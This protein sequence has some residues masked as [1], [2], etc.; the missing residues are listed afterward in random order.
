MTDEKTIKAG[1]E[2][3]SKK[4]SGTLKLANASFMNMSVGYGQ[5]NPWAYTQIDKL[6]DI[7]EKEF[8]KLVAACRFFYRHDPIVSTV[9]NKMIDIGI[10]DLRFKKTKLSANEIRIVES[11]I[12]DLELFAENMALE[13][14]ISGLVVP[15]VEYGVVSKD[16]MQPYGIKKYSRLILPQSLWLRD[17]TTIKINSALVDTPS[18]FVEIPENI[19][20]FIMNGGV[21]PDGTEDKE[22]YARLAEHYPEFVA[23]VKNG[24]KYVLL[25][26]D[27]IFRR[28]YTT[29]SPYPIPYLNSVIESLRH[30]RNIKRMDYA[31]AARVIGAIQ[32]FKLGSDD[33][34]VTQDQDEQFEA[35]KEQMTYRYS[36]GRD[37]E[38]IFQLFA[39]H[40]LSIEWI[41]PD[42]AALLDDTKYKDVNNSIVLGLGFPR[43]LMT[44]ETERTGTS[45]HEF[46]TMSPIK[47]MDRFRHRIETVLNKIITKVFEENNLKG[48]TEIEFEPI[49]MH[50]F[51][52][53]ITALTKLY[54]T[55]NLS[56]EEFA[57]AFGY[58]IEEEFSKISEEK[59][60]MSKYDIEEFPA[61]PFTPQA[62]VPNNSTNKDNNKK[63]IK[64]KSV[65]SN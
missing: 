39:N 21:Y 48:T 61:Q 4:D 65:N 51:T 23:K 14:L 56:R 54:E 29:D 31:I 60:L 47:T 12:E 1:I 53:F 57:D 22:L 24:E 42:V 58:D 46:A 49:N 10:T 5:D 52:D 37:I 2:I 13:Y 38:R 18:Y 7:D 6:E 63:N 33:F 15:E 44:G 9:L 40:T 32:L 3:E 26:N 41:M 27:L 62:N 17:P 19:R 25:E 50:N 30:K 43:I 55:G 36:G 20:F 11:M 35:I 28:R 45:D 8:R 16:E 59:D 34:P 64:E